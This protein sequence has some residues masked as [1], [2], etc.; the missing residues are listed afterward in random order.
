[1]LKKNGTWITACLVLALFTTCIHAKDDPNDY[2]PDFQKQKESIRRIC[3]FGDVMLVKDS[4]PGLINL[5]DNLK[6]WN[7]FVE[8]FGEQLK[9]KN[10]TL[11]KTVL[12]SVGMLADVALD[13][14]TND[15]ISAGYAPYYLDDTVADDFQLKM[16]LSSLYRQ[17]DVYNPEKASLTLEPEL[18]DRL[19]LAGFD[20]LFVVQ[21]YGH[22]GSGVDMSGKIWNSIGKDIGGIGGFFYI[23]DLGSGDLIWSYRH[24]FAGGV[25]RN[26]GKIVNVFGKKFS[27]PLPAK[28]A[29][30]DEN[31]PVEKSDE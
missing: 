17:L 6:W 7:G 21:L 28:D 3:L 8:I 4:Q 22:V 1:V 30:G 26:L 14:K 11:E 12:T 16:A 5:T 19:K 31:Q 18:I 24:F 20:T 10:F 25:E 29:S 15:K 2:Y 13:V 27:K 9:M 23:V